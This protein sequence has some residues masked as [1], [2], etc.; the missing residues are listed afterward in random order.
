MFI[1]TQISMTQ[2]FMCLSRKK[3]CV[4]L[5]AKKHQ[6]VFICEAVLFFYFIICFFYTQLAFVFSSFLCLLHLF[7]SFFWLLKPSV[8]SSTCFCKHSQATLG[9]L[10]LNVQHLYERSRGFPKGWQVS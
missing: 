7:I 9:T 1:K 3:S 2:R 8:L 4:W 10:P 5:L 6:S